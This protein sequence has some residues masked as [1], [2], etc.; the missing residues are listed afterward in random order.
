[1]FG[2]REEGV[3]LNGLD[4]AAEALRE[5]IETSADRPFVIFEGERFTYAEMFDRSCRFGNLAIERGARRVAVLADNGPDVVAAIFGCALAGLV[6]V[7]LDPGR[8]GVDLASDLATTGADLLLLEPKYAPLLDD[9]TMDEYVRSGSFL[10]VD[11][12]APAGLIEPSESLDAALLVSSASDP[13]IAPEGGDLALI[14]IC[15][16]ED[17]RSVRWTHRRLMQSV[18]LLRTRLGEA[19][20]GSGWTAHRS[21]TP[22]GLVHGVL[23]CA[24]AGGS[25]VVSRFFSAESMRRDLKSHSASWASLEAGQAAEVDLQQTDAMLVVCGADPA[26]E[27][28]DTARFDF[29]CVWTCESDTGVHRTTDA[30]AWE[31]G[32]W[33]RVADTKGR[34][35]AVGQKA[36]LQLAGECV[37]DGYEDDDVGTHKRMRGGS[38]DTRLLAQ[39][40]ETGQIVF[41]P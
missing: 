41:S 28:A 12:E 32:P 3:I 39:L 30:C 33:A 10:V 31:P 40:N 13:D 14:H 4:S 22:L 21:A 29:E 34:T 6:L 1:M 17:V 27:F 24:T 38:F 15:Y 19:V 11:R 37:F 25:L 35:P 5:R 26:T 20:L 18:D 9:E 7:T 2:L 16:A 23:A 8:K 36:R